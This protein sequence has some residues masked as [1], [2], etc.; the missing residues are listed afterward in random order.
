MWRW[1][2]G[3]FLLVLAPGQAGSV[4]VAPVLLDMTAPAAATLL[5]LRNDQKKPLNVQVR[6]YQWQQAGGEERLVPTREIVVSPPIATIQ[7]GGEQVVRVVR[8]SKQ[9]PVGEESYRVLVDEL[10]D[11]AERRDGRVKLVLRHSIPVFFAEPSR[12]PPR[13]TWSII[14]RGGSWFLEGANAGGR[15]LRIANFSLKDATG[16]VI[17]NRSG[18]LGYVLAGGSIRW[19]LTPSRELKTAGTAVLTADT[20]TGPMHATAHIRVGR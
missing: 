3:A 7:P 10:P 16:N 18:L 8:L 9:A 14:E 13:V 20:E 6:A 2:L 11:A 1:L 5:T 12:A 4:S 17:A 19:P 15:R